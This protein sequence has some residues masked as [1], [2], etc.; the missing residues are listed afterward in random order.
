M[1]YHIDM[2]NANN[3]LLNLPIAREAT[4]HSEWVHNEHLHTEANEKWTLVCTFNTCSRRLIFLFFFVLFFP[5]ADFCFKSTLIATLEVQMGSTHD[6]LVAPRKTPFP[7]HV[8]TA[9]VGKCVRF[10]SRRL[11]SSRAE[12]EA[13]QIYRWSQNEALASGPLGHIE[14]SFSVCPPLGFQV[15]S[16]HFFFFL[17]GCKSHSWNPL[18]RCTEV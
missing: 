1:S 4:S 2:Y 15:C 8:K 18:K 7:Q 9:K 5:F 17:S 11:A 14:T 10:Y 16:L 12:C 6:T 13:L 3:R